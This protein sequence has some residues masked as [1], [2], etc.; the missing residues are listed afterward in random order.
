MRNPFEERIARRQCSADEGQFDRQHIGQQNQQ[1]RQR[2]QNQKGSNRLPQPQF[3][4]GEGAQTG[5][6]N[7]GVEVTVGNIIHHATGGAHQN[8]TG[9]K[10]QDIFDRRLA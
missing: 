2:H 6:L 8:D 9:G 3:S 7:V 5:A 4:G 10:Y 1:K